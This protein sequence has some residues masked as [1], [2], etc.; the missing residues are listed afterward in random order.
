VKP[1]AFEATET[2]LVAVTAAGRNFFAGA[3]GGGAVS[4]RLPK[5][6]LPRLAAFAAKAGVII[7]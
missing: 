5:S 2:E 1:A 7:G 4:C 3:F 6:E